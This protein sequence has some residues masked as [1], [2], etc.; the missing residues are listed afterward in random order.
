M[1]NEKAV[2]ICPA[3]GEAVY[4]SLEPDGPVWTCPKDLNPTNPY[5]D[6]DNH[7]PEE[8]LAQDGD[9][10]NCPSA[11]TLDGGYCEGELHLPLHAACYT[12]GDY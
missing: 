2:G 3:C 9:H 1:R 6:P 4:T 12:K 11:H 8:L 10:S 5:Y 7:A